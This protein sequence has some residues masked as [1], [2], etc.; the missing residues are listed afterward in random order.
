LDVVWAAAPGA[1]ASAAV[2]AR[3]EIVARRIGAQ[4]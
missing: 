1:Q 3:A 4:G 2:S